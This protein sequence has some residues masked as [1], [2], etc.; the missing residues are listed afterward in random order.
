M[1]IRPALIIFWIGLLA[2]GILDSGSLLAL[3]WD[4]KAPKE[5]D[6]NLIVKKTAPKENAAQVEA[7]IRNKVEYKAQGLKNPFQSPFK[8]KE[9]KMEPKKEVDKA[10]GPK[11]GV[12]NKQPTPTVV[13]NLPK[14]IVQ[15]LIWGGAFPQ[16]IINNTVV[17]KGDVISDAKVVEINSEG[18]TVLFNRKEYNLSSPSVLDQQQTEEKPEG[19]SSSVG[20]GYAPV[21]TYPPAAV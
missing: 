21:S 20:V 9:V 17:R 11:M 6:E 2:P 8:E 3:E 7:I 5:L 1:K 13:V 14:L 10:M 19:N 18:V 4:A 15:G 12:E 16:A